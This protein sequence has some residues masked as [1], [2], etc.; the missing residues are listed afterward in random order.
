LIV[1]AAVLSTLPG[2]M[3]AATPAATP[4]VQGAQ[5]GRDAA[6]RLAAITQVVLIGMAGLVL[7]AVTAWVIL[8]LIKHRWGM[9][10]PG[11]SPTSIAQL[12]GRGR[13]VRKNN[14]WQEAGRRLQ[15][16]PRPPG[17]NLGQA[18]DD[19]PDDPSRG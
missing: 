17:T 8:T 4:A 15:V 11:V 3:L 6:V 14:P 10:P 19:M 2:L 18:L 7:L 5:A 16:E 13:H 1:N 9:Q 12:G